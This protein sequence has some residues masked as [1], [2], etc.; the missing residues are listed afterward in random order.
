M[1]GRNTGRKQKRRVATDKPTTAS[2]CAPPCAAVDIGHEPAVKLPL[3][4]GVGA[5]PIQASADRG[6]HAPG[7]SGFRDG[8]GR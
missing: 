5:S 4:P 8:G 2:E 1:N 3:A 6:V 7:Q